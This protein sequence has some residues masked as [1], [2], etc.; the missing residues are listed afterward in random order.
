MTNFVIQQATQE[1]D[2]VLTE[3]TK[4]AKAYWNYSAVQLLEWADVLTVSKEYI[5]QNHT[6][7]LLTDGGKTVGYYSYY[8]QSAQVVKLDN[9]FILPDY[10][11][12]GYG[13]LLLADFFDKIKLTAAEKV[14]L[15]AE[16]NVEDF[17]QKFG[18]RTVGR[19]ESSIK[20][21]FLPI[22]EKVLSE[23]T[24]P[25]M[26]FLFSFYAGILALEA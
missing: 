19:L 10:I 15:D 1:D 7:K 23:G 26:A 2:L 12:K 4:L 21:R 25:A 17:Y 22:M 24:G 5:A 20:N 6:Y 14:V 9:L 18:F 16:P 13:R 8:P 11:G 3:I